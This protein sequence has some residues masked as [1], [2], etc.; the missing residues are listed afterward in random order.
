MVE[1]DFFL[2]V[3]IDAGFEEFSEK[4]EEFSDPFFTAAPVFS[5]E[6]P[7]SKIGDF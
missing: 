1:F 6:K 7:E 5:R 3:L 4:V 2:V